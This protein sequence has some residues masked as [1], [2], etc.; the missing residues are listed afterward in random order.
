MRFKITAALLSLAIVL[1]NPVDTNNENIKEGS[2]SVHHR[3]GEGKDKEKRD[4]N[5][6]AEASSLDGVVNFCE[7]VKEIC[8]DTAS[9][10]SELFTSDDESSMSNEDKKYKL[11]LEKHLK[12]VFASIPKKYIPEG[13]MDEYFKEF[14]ESY[15][16]D[17]KKYRFLPK[18]VVVVDKSKVCRKDKPET[19]NCKR[20]YYMYYFNFEV[21]MCKE[22]GSD[23]EKQPDNVY[24][25]AI[26]KTKGKRRTIA[27]L[28]AKD[29]TTPEG[30]FWVDNIIEDP[31]AYYK[32]AKD[33]QLQ[34]I[35]PRYGPRM[36]SLD[37]PINRR[38][39]DEIAIHGSV[40]K[41]QDTIGT[42][43]SYGCIR[44]NN[45]E[46]KAVYELLEGQFGK[47]IGE[48]VIITP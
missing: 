30:I 35:G 8:E 46:I 36:I 40:R 27:G 13:F 15:F 4:D 32:S 21:E 22:K 48:L 28:N 39:Y 25:V 42:N 19:K 1:G 44:M 3:K 37:V 26:G 10:T 23:E 33:P 6:D 12:D 34:N 29:R 41:L 47:G 16:E 11:R 2:V 24:E 17:Y 18:A 9:F 45:Q 20:S 43:V 5:A 31:V 38:P 7:R 14:F